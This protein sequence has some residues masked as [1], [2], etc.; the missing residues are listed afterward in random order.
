MR[1]LLKNGRVIDPV[2]GRDETLDLLIEK[3]KIVECKPQIKTTDARVMDVSRKVVLPGLIDMHVHLR[4]PGQEYKETIQSGGTAAARGGFTAV[5]CMPNTKPVN[6]R[7][8]VT[9]FIRTEARRH[10]P[11][12]VFPIA[13]ITLNLEGEN[14]TDMAELK[15]AGAV[16]FSDDGHSVVDS[17]VMR[18]AMEYA[19]MNDLLLIDHC[20]DPNLTASGVMHEGAVSY[21]IG[22]R[23]IPSAGEE[24]IVARDITLAGHFNA[25]L[26]IAHLSTAG[27]ADMVRA[28]KKQGIAITA[29]VTPH[30]VLLSD[31]H[32]RGYDTNYKMSPPLRGE[33]DIKA[34]I[35]AVQDGTIDVFVT[36]HAP[37]SPDDK[38]MEFDYAPFGIIGLESAVPL[39][40]DR[41]VHSGLISLQ[42]FAEM[43]SS[44][45][46]RI[47]GLEGKGRIEPGADADLTVLNLSKKHT[48]DVSAFAS[49]GRNCPFNGWTVLGQPEITIVGGRVVYEAV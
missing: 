39:L 24:V 43:L 35:K 8:D 12:H 11:V 6:D 22:L 42:R 27:S 2:S 45:P 28:A 47:L 41:F 46:A 7:R 31:N 26:H 21:A 37:H 30:H 3:G 38:E 48:I 1:L 44:N 16:A 17:Q 25:R 18:R 36:D 33:S 4:E 5:A 15:K 40:L 32:L 20:E 23:G 19:R 34:L 29:E 13:A 49:K 10:S 14:L 9:E